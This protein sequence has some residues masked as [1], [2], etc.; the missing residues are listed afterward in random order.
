M[1]KLENILFAFVL[2]LCIFSCGE[3]SVADSVMDRA[4][5]CMETAP[6]SAFVVLDSLDR[7][8]LRTHQQKARY[9]LLYSI[10]LDKV[11][12]NI[13]NDSI[14][15]VAVDY[16]NGKEREEYEKALLYQEK[17]HQN[18]LAY[19]QLDTLSRQH[20]RIIEER[21]SDKIRLV[22]METNKRTMAR[23][24]CASIVLLCLLVLSTL[25]LVR[26]LRQRPDEKAMAIIKERLAILDR[27]LA[28]HITDNPAFDRIA[29]KNI[30]SLVND[31]ESFLDSCRVIVT[32]TH[33]AFAKVLTDAGLTDWEIGYCCLYILGL[34]G[35][36]VGEYTRKK[37]HYIIDHEIRQKLGLDEHDTN[38]SLY[39]RKLLG[40]TEFRP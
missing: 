34:R 13:C 19:S 15:N 6:D 20:Q 1:R 40:E 38:L 24:L 16:F 37:R 17:I 10:A 21:F 9:A 33:P 30:D 11:G 7:S 5:F 27:I 12:I 28:A 22:Q 26:K 3:D 8:M 2:L 39:L 35:K 29:E 18:A 31:R 36:E 4:E 23:V 25:K 32:N 14:I